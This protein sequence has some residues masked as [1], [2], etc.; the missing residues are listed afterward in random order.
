MCSRGS[1]GTQKARRWEWLGMCQEP[2]ECCGRGQE[3]SDNGGQSDREEALH[4]GG[5]HQSLLPGDG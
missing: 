4:V 2:R 1:S 5:G 3:S